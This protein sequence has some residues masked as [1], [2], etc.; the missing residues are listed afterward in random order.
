MVRVN[1]SAPNRRATLAGNGRSKKIQMCAPLPERERS[2][3][4]EPSVRGMFCRTLRRRPS[5]SFCRSRRLGT[6]KFRPATKGGR[7]ASGWRRDE[8]GWLR[9]SVEYSGEFPCQPVFGPRVWQ[10]SKPS[11]LARFSA[12]SRNGHPGSPNAGR[13]RHR[14]RGI[15]IGTK[16]SS[17]QCLVQVP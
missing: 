6:N 14:V 8:R 2:T 12:S 3:Q 17:A 9:R 11:S 10:H 1:S 15:T 16:Q 5:K 4:P 7:R 13:I